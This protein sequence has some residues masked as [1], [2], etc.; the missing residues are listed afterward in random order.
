MYRHRKI[1]GDVCPRFSLDF[2]VVKCQWTC[3]RIARRRRRSRFSGVST[4]EDLFA[5]VALCSMCGCLLRCVQD[6]FPSFRLLFFCFSSCLTALM[7]WRLF[8][9]TVRSPGRRAS[10]CRGSSEGVDGAQTKS[11]TKEG[12]TGNSSRVRS[13]S[14]LLL[15]LLLLLTCSSLVHEVLFFQLSML[16]LLEIMPVDSSAYQPLP[17]SR[18]YPAEASCV[19]ALSACFPSSRCVRRAA[20]ART[21]NLLPHAKKERHAFL[22]PQTREQNQ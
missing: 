1:H 6:L 2:F 12:P 19:R 22:P 3:R 10:R 16:A 5:S 7:E 9:F 17:F 4:A 20:S 18:A 8:V 11:S 13:L 14:S 21:R 15:L